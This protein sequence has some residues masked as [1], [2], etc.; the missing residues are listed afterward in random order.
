MKGLHVC[1]AIIRMC[2]SL[3][4][5]KNKNK[6][7]TIYSPKVGVYSIVIAIYSYSYL[8]YIVL[9]HAACMYACTIL[10]CTQFLHVHSSD[11]HYNY[12][13]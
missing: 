1:S 11:K 4:Y 12:Y 7:I 6:N 8:L 5:R 3:P 10:A 13:I 2:A 9:R